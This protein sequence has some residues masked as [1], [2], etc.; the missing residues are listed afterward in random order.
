MPKRLLLPTA[1][2]ES[3]LQNSL[4][5]G[6]KFIEYGGDRIRRGSVAAE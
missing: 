5:D 1:T 6:G 3:Q 4:S 2:T